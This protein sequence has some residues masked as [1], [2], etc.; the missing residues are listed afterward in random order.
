MGVSAQCGA[1]RLTE[2][3]G[4]RATGRR[5][6]EAE[7]RRSWLRSP[8][9]AHP[10]GPLSSRLRSK[11]RAGPMPFN[12]IAGARWRRRRRPVKALKSSLRAERLV[13]RPRIG[14]Q[15]SKA[16]GGSSTKPRAI[17]RS[18]SLLPNR[19]GH[20]VRATE[21]SAGWARRTARGRA[22][23]PPAPGLAVVTPPGLRH[24]RAALRRAATKVF[25]DAIQRAHAAWTI[26]ASTT[27]GRR[28]RHGAPA[29]A[30]FASQSRYSP[31]SRG[32]TEPMKAT[33][34]RADG[35]LGEP[36]DRHRRASL[37]RG[38]F[39]TRALVG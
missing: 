9:P 4:E 16:I 18:M 28:W 34:S 10:A 3:E 14:F 36:G 20:A 22:P 17:P 25:T 31:A 1:S 35:G 12:S 30:R 13:G 32:H 19:A 23:S 29:S 6:H 24:R 15:L 27:M 21:R 38:R 8:R 5:R 26:S 33:D 39:G 37:G 11:I 7:R 2:P